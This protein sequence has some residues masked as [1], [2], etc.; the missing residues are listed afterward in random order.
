[1]GLFDIFKTN[2]QQDNPVTRWEQG[3]EAINIYNKDLDNR[4]N[5]FDSIKR[6]NAVLQIIGFVAKD[7][8]TYC[9]EE[10]KDDLYILLY[11]SAKH[12][13]TVFT[14]VEVDENAQFAMIFI[15]ETV[16]GAYGEESELFNNLVNDWYESC[17][18]I[19]PE[20]YTKM[21]VAVDNKRK[22]ENKQED[23]TSTNYGNKQGVSFTGFKQGYMK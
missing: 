19:A 4:E 21:N 6:I 12:I 17:E 7:V 16:K 1:M 5:G 13:S 10:L 11:N 8:D 23:N 2:K 3:I 20:F 9:K 14:T 18:E 15:T 22:E